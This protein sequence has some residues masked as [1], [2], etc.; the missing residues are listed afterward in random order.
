MNNAVKVILLIAVVAVVIF[1][2]WK[3][4][5][6]V[7]ETAQLTARASPVRRLEGS[8]HSVEAVS[9]GSKCTMYQ[10][11]GVNVEQ[12]G[13]AELKIAGCCLDICQDS[14]LK[15]APSTEAGAP[16]CTV[17]MSHGTLVAAVDKEMVLNTEWCVIRTLG[18]R[19]LV[20]LDDARGLVWVIVQEGRVEVI[21][22]SRR[23]VVRPGQQ[24]WVR[25]DGQI[26]PVRPATRGE[27]GDL[28]PP[29]E[30]LTGDAIE[31]PEWLDESVVTQTP[32]PPTTATPTGITTPTN[33]PLPTPS[34][35]PTQCPFPVDL[36]L[37]AA[38]QREP[39]GCATSEAET[40]WAA[41]QS[42]ENGYMLWR[43]SPREIISFCSSGACRGS[44][45]RW[46]DP[47]REG[48][49]LPPAAAPL[50][51]V[52]IVRGFGYLWRTEEIVRD[53]LGCATA[54]E[55]GFCA[56][57]QD[58][59]RGFIF[60]SADGPCPDGEGQF[61]ET[62]DAFRQQY[63]ELFFGLKGINGGTWLPY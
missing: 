2:V 36:E 27:V 10:G 6:G 11:D 28:F 53:Q 61:W 15:W 32:P 17:D 43:S 4:I 8:T 38:W 47:W 49:P 26:A 3:I 31:D 35:T 56:R 9:V 33:T 54:E 5:G 39:F 42:F 57:V 16:V 1:V 52:P 34:P 18:T 45:M 30:E 25:R 22:D 60:H 23:V 29:L 40:V 41:W 44:W 21:A 46:P 55:Q 13:R 37:S 58:F 59:P 14:G 48:T 20:H 51:E 62:L 63:G 19:F 24:T 50:C 7:K 12:Q